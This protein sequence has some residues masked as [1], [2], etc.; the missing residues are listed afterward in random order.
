VHLKGN[1][2]HLHTQNCLHLH[3][4]HCIYIY[5]YLHDDGVNVL[6]L[7]NVYIYSDYTSSL[8]SILIICGCILELN[9]VFAMGHFLLALPKKNLIFL[10]LFK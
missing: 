9:I 10:A 4:S 3:C 1:Q 6:G 2:L 8:Q 7:V 5:T